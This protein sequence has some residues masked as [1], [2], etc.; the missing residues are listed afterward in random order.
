VRG[1]DARIEPAA[2][3]VVRA[4]GD[5]GQVGTHGQSGRELLFANLLRGP[6]AD[7]EVG[8]EQPALFRGDA[9]REAV[10][11][12]AV[13]SLSV[14]IVES[15]AGAVADG[16]VALE[17]GLHAGVILRRAD[18]AGSPADGAACVHRQGIPR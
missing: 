16:D 10:C 17:A 7:G 6:A 15:F 11:P 5:G 14:R 8:V 12:A 3:D 13:A 9:L 2:E 18:D 4:A 1:V